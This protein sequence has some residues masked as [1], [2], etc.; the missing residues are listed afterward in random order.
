M[1]GTA[2][3]LAIVAWLLKTALQ[4][5][6]ARGAEAFK[7][8]LKADAD[9]E[10]ERLKNSLQIVATEHQV[11]FSK[12]HEKRAEVIGELYKKLTNVNLRGERFVITAE[13]NPTPHKE[14]EFADMREELRE[15][16]I[17]VE[18]HRIYLPDSVCTFLDTPPA[19]LTST[20]S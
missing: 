8:H 13:N 16:F 19:H 9:I 12:L 18:Q 3:I 11:R 14:K 17:F 10:I 4:E 15:V 1:G 20:V 6:I 5:W 2:V 7:T